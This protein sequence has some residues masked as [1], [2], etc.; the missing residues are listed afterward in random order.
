MGFILGV[1]LTY[2]GFGIGYQVSKDDFDLDLET[3]KKIIKWPKY[4]F[5]KKEDKE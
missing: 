1:V 4:A 3:A 2:I 5:A